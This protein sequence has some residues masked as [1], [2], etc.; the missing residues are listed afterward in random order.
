MN[1]RTGAIIKLLENYTISAWIID[2]SQTIVYMNRL[3]QDLFGNL[4]GEKT[5]IIYENNEPKAPADRSPTEVIIADVPFRRTGSVI[6][7]GADGK[8]EVEF[9]EDISEQKLVHTNMTQALAKI[10]VETKMAKNIQNSILPID[11]TYWDTIAYSSLYVPAGDLSGDFY[12]LLKL[13]DDEYLLYIADVSGHGIQASLLTIFM[14]ERV[15]THTEAALMG[16]GALLTKLV[17]DFV[18]LDVDRSLY[19]TMAICKYSK[20]RRELTISNAGHNCSPLIIRDNGRAET[21]PIRGVPVC[22]IA[23]GLDYEEEVVSMNPG[24]RLI[25]FTDG[26]V[27]EVD[28][29]KGRAFGPEGVRALAEKYHE[30]S[31]DYLVRAIIDESA[32]YALINAKDDRS[33]VVADILS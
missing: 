8:F 32:R 19:I 17:K 7:F 18:T 5:S 31:G 4:E 1:D 20:S 26:I 28:S 24:D 11:D 29:L 21:I 6:D 10:N 13:N 25:L 33:I 12:D 27:E 30:Y 9:F 3:M 14:R 2:A 15:R 23:D 16:T 22:V